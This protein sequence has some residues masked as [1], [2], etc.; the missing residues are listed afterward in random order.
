MKVLHVIYFMPLSKTNRN[1]GGGPRVT[2]AE[3]KESAYTHH[4]VDCSNVNIFDTKKYPIRSEAD[5][6]INTIL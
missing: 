5:S 4:N 6:F 1:V 3:N 2:S